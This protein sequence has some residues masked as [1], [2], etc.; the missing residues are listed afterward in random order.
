VQRLGDALVHTLNDPEEPVMM[1]AI[2]GLGEMR[3][4]R[5]VEALTHVHQYYKT[6][7]PALAALDA[8]AR[9]GLRGS[10]PLF[11]TSATRREPTAR[12][13]AVEGLAR[14]GDAEALAALAPAVQADGNREVA[15]GVAFASQRAGLGKHLSTLIAEAGGRDTGLQVQDYL[16]ELG[17][18]VAG[19]VAAAL[20]SA[21]G[22]ARARLIEVLGVI[23]GQDE[24]PAIEAARADGSSRVAVAAERAM[25]R[26]NTPAR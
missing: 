4:E 9:I 8:L 19:E 3:Y 21:R 18:P 2:E 17:P 24:V 20:A 14:A 16:V 12:R 25:R 7:P 23:G 13:A 15:L 11:K 10:I 26:I 1:A 5:G 6:G 22:E